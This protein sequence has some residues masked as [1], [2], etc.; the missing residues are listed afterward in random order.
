[1]SKLIR[2]PIL[3]MSKKELIAYCLTIEH[4]YFTLKDETQ[5]LEGIINHVEKW[6]D[7][8][9]ETI[10]LFHDKYNQEQI[11][12]ENDSLISLVYDVQEPTFDIPTIQDQVNSLKV[13][14]RTR[15]VLQALHENNNNQTIVAEKLGITQ[16]AVAH[17]VRKAKEK[18]NNGNS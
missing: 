13:S 2:K 7:H 8:H 15:E 17:H 18:A 14:A 11:D 9:R 16:S 10:Q 12:D 6:N 4:L 3:K 1:M 5:G